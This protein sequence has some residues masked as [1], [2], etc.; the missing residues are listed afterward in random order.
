MDTKD[1]SLAG[2]NPAEDVSEGCAGVY[3]IT[4]D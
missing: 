3:E 1:S 4:G 2:G